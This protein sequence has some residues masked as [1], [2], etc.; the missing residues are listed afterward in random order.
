MTEDPNDQ[1]SKAIDAG[2][3]PACLA[4][5]DAG[6]DVNYRQ[7]LGFTALMIA[8]SR[9]DTNAVD[10]LLTRG[11]KVNA[12]NRGGATALTSAALMGHLEVVRSLVHAG[13]DIE[14]QNT[15]GETPLFAA[16]SN[17]HREVVRALLKAGA[18]PNRQSQHGS[19]PLMHA[20]SSADIE[21]VRILLNAGADRQL[22]DLNGRTAYQWAVSLGRTEI[23][24]LLKQVEETPA[25]AS[26]S[27]DV[28]PVPSRSRSG[29]EL[30]ADAEDILLRTKPPA[31]LAAVKTARRQPKK[32]TRV[33]GIA[34]I[35]LGVMMAASGI[36][37]MNETSSKNSALGRRAKP[38]SGREVTPSEASSIVLG[39]GV[40]MMGIGIWLTVRRR[41]TRET[42]PDGST[43]QRHGGT[44]TGKN[45]GRPRELKSEVPGLLREIMDAVPVTGEAQE[46]Q[47]ERMNNLISL[48]PEVIPNIESAIQD[49]ANYARNIPAYE[50]AGQLCEA[51]G[52]IGGPRAHLVLTKIATQESNIAEF[53]W[54]VR[55]GAKKGLAYLENGTA[56]ALSKMGK[57]RQASEP[58]EPLT[59]TSIPGLLDTGTAQAKAGECLAA[60]ESFIRAV[61][62]EPEFMMDSSAWK[63]I[64]SVFT[65]K[66]APGWGKN[67]I[68]VPK[69]LIPDDVLKHL[70]RLPNYSTLPGYHG[71]YV[72]PPTKAEILNLI[73]DLRIILKHFEESVSGSRPG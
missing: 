67:W 51:I 59:R 8:A 13:A 73:A 69:E 68:Y 40:L 47:K 46:S 14:A 33:L 49:G 52:K 24:G 3:V 36:G 30:L 32:W 56:E 27:S 61:E 34:L 41:R 1:L 57:T 2:D 45:S 26:A 29:E 38:R 63:H 53:H 44:S 5:V 10:S 71:P 66:D 15:S 65:G 25:K 17:G 64:S 72:Q 16:C 22:S 70:E 19:T 21:T 50:N 42:S 62:I 31:P 12:K 6:A 7:S 55:S 4:A 28:T 54:Y 39:Q 18:K 20:V 43:T 48:G 35:L 23:A 58:D 11:A 60:V 37:V 9:D